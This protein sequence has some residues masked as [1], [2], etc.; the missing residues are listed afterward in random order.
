M[1]SQKFLSKLKER[2]RELWNYKVFKYAVIIHGGYFIFSLFLTLIFF[3]KQND[4]RVYYEVG[5]VVLENINDLYTPPTP[6]N[7]PFRYLPI[8]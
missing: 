7:W 8:A 1:K 4:F 5:G 3:R 6:Y 2:F